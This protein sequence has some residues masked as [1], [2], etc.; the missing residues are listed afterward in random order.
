MGYKGPVE[1]YYQGVVRGVVTFKCPGSRCY[2]LNGQ[3]PVEYLMKPGL[4]VL[5]LEE[6]LRKSLRYPRYEDSQTKVDKTQ[7]GWRSHH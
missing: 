4:D 5:G 7:Q 6:E 1:E 3:V 2:G